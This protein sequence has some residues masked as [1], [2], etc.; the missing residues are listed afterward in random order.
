MKSAHIFL[1]LMLAAPVLQPPTARAGADAISPDSDLGRLQGRW[2]GKTGARRQI[3]VLLEVRGRQVNAHITTPQGIRIQAR[4]EVNLFE[5]ASP[6]KVDWVKFRAGDD[7]E[8]PQIAG[9]YRLE[10]D[11]FTVCNG[12]FNGNRPADFISGDGVLAQVV[13][14][15][16]VSETTANKSSERTEPRR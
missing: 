10:R 1:A 9:I 11:T 14:F 15:E 7:Q 5:S 16:R 4:G 3:R 8:F 12:G 13:V 2:A 6:R